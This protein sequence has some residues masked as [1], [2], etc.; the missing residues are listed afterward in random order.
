MNVDFPSKFMFS[1]CTNSYPENIDNYRKK[2]KY[3][4]LMSI[5]RISGMK[6]WEGFANY[7]KKQY[8]A[9]RP[10][11]SQGRNHQPRSKVGGTH[12]SSHMCSRG[13]SC[14]ASTGVEALGPGKA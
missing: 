11:S 3:K 4:L 9:T 6:D 2:D 13:W 8:Q 14:W 10:Q 5:K 7:R 12:G 1:L